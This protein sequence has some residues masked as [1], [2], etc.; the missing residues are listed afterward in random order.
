ML[1][2]TNFNDNFNANKLAQK[3]NTCQ[4]FVP[5]CFA[6]KIVVRNCSVFR[7]TAVTKGII[8]TRSIKR[9]VRGHIYTRS[10]SVKLDT[11]LVE[12]IVINSV[13]SCPC[14]SAFTG[15]FEIS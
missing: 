3:V 9:H 2:R 7:V 12:L 13:T 4:T 8:A 11:Q 5:A 6:L 10:W 1:H 15:S 14:L